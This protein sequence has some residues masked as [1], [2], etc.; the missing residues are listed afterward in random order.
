MRRSVLAVLMAAALCV[1]LTGTASA[2]QSFQATF[3]S[4]TPKKDLASCTHFLCAS[5]SVSGYGDA[6][7]TLDLAGAPVTSGRCESAPVTVTI[8]L[9][10]GSGTLT[11]AGP[12]TACFPGR[13]GDA[14]GALKSFG[15]PFRGTAE[16]SVTQGT[17]VFAG[18]SGTL[19]ATLHSAGA[20]L[21]A[22]LTGTLD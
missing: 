9:T 3:K 11:L 10:D 4:N 8:T 1:G 21:A 22:Q 16:L 19:S 2:Q 17:G 18:A 12:A 20:H 6:S 5:G 13:S 14:P 15:N 7:V